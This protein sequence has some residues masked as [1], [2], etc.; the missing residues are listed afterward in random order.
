[1]PPILFSFG[2]VDLK[3]YCEGSASFDLW[4]AHIGARR[5][6]VESIELLDWS[7]AG[8]SLSIQPFSRRIDDFDVDLTLVS[9]PVSFGEAQVNKIKTVLSSDIDSPIL[10]HQGIPYDQHLEILLRPRRRGKLPAKSFSVVVPKA[11][12]RATGSLEHPARDTWR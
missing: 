7:F 12:V 10:R 6:P 4:L 9:V 8:L 1:M 2:Y 3:S 11:V 5:P